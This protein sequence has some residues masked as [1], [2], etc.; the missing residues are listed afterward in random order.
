[1]AMTSNAHQRSEIAIVLQAEL[2]A[3]IRR[4]LA[5][6]H[7]QFRQ[8]FRL[9]EG[10][11]VIRNRLLRLGNRGVFVPAPIW[12]QPAA[13]RGFIRTEH[14][15][16][17]REAGVQEGSVVI[18]GGVH[19]FHQRQKGSAVETFEAGFDVN[20]AWRGFFHPTPVTSTP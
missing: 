18:A 15:V 17:Q 13:Q 4:V 14:V 7:H 9:A 20:P 2:V 6:E 8:A 12:P 19:V 3:E 10:L 11:L 5:I 16:A 1:M